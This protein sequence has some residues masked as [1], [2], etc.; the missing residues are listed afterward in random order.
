MA[1]TISKDLRK[2]LTD[3]LS[4][5]SEHDLEMLE[6]STKKLT[7]R[8]RTMAKKTTNRIIFR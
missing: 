4:S 1:L 2:Q 8:Q 5:L 7:G 6:S 3:Y